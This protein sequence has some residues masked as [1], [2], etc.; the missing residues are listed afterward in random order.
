M[1]LPVM[2]LP[3]FAI[4]LLITLLGSGCG[5]KNPVPDGAELIWKGKV[6]SPDVW[7]N[8]HWETN[9]YLYLVDAGSG[10][11]LE[12][13]TVWKE[14]PGFTFNIDVNHEYELHFKPGNTAESSP[15]E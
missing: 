12:T 6:D 3:S 9:G 7:K 11:V 4:L 10:E 13:R 8:L 5:Q 2:R 1:H 14:K 15:D